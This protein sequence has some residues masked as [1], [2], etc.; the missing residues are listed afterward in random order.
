MNK[1]T[2]LK[3]SRGF[4]LVELLV[5]IALIGVLS[6]IALVNYQVVSESAYDATAESDYREIKT[7]IQAVILD[8]TTPARFVIRRRTGP[9]VFPSPLSMVGLSDEVVGSVNYRYQARVNRPAL[10]RIIVDV[11]HLRGT[12]RFRYTD[13]NGSV[14]EQVIA[15]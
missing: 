8:P 15:R 4:T 6:G 7:A 3:N 13:V 11:Q 14:T 10:S 12:K 1:R 9:S 2:Y 5:V